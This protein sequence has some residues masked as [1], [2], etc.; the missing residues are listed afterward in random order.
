MHIQS[1]HP[2]TLCS[3]LLLP[4]SWSNGHTESVLSESHSVL[5]SSSVE[6]SRHT[7]PTGPRG[8]LNGI[9]GPREGNSF[10]RHAR[11]TPDS[12]RDSPHSERYHT[13][14]H[15]LQ[16]ARPG[17][18]RGFPCLAPQE[19]SQQCCSCR[20]YLPSFVKVE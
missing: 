16:L 2:L 9:G 14:P 5:V 15:F 11:E 12:Y 1:K 20:T 7:S 8:R 3:L 18:P 17:E 13:L 6:N 4:C 19:E 10:L